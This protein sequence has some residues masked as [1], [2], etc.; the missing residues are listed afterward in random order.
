MKNALQKWIS[1]SLFNL[2]LVAIIGVTLRYKIVY[3]LPIVNQKYLLHAH[4]HFAFTGWVTMALMA[5]LV[6][7]LKQYQNPNAFKKYKP[8][9]WLNL[10]AA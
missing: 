3:A 2:L 10:I 1:V 4:S 9:L 7:Y 6:Q 8:V 5:L